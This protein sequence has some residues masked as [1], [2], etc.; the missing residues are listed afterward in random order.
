MISL[1][2]RTDLAA[3][4]SARGIAG[5]ARIVLVTTLAALLALGLASLSLSSDQAI[6]KLLYA[7]SPMLGLTPL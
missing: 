6:L 4:S 1:H 2:N 7:L 5:W 3:K